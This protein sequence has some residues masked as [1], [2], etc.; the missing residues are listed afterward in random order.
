MNLPLEEQRRHDQANL[1][2]VILW[3]RQIIADPSSTDE[4]RAAAREALQT[5]DYPEAD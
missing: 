1:E 3:A 5:A 4:D 2:T